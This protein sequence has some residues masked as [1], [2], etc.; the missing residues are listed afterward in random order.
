MNRLSGAFSEKEEEQLT[1]IQLMKTRG[2]T[3]KLKHGTFGITNGAESYEFVEDELTTT[4][5]AFELLLKGLIGGR[6]TSLASRGLS[7]GKLLNIAEKMGCEKSHGGLKE[8]VKRQQESRMLE[9]EA[10][11]EEAIVSF[12]ELFAKK[13]TAFRVE[14]V[15]QHELAYL[16][17]AFPQGTQDGPDFVVQ[18]EKSMTYEA[19][20]L[21]TAAEA[22]AASPEVEEVT[23]EEAGDQGCLEETTGDRMLLDE[24]KRY[25]DYNTL[26]LK[27]EKNDKR[28][29]ELLQEVNEAK[30][31]PQSRLRNITAKL[32]VGTY[33][34]EEYIARFAQGIAGL[35]EGDALR[36]AQI[37]IFLR[38]AQVVVNGN[39][40]TKAN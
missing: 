14:D 19:E 6:E 8:A 39:T 38:G 22:V 34:A 33:P 3:L 35:V 20:K 11:G 4:Q 21:V 17:G 16:L 30:N 1:V 10:G 13:P 9:D 18:G 31:L 27:S 12:A 23:P 28:A 5:T 25:V 32:P 36:K 7:Y 2:W 29:S 15:A 37:F 40:I 26:K 24:L